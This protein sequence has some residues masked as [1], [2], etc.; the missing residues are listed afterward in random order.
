MLARLGV[1][2]IWLRVWQ[3]CDVK[4]AKVWY[5]ET[6][7]LAWLGAE[8]YLTDWFSV[9]WCGTKRGTC[10]VEGRLCGQDRELD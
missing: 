6:Y 5:R 9:W 7:V 1:R 4:D 2:L 8:S 10:G 3:W